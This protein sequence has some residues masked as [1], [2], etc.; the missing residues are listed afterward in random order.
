MN[1]YKPLLLVGVFF[2]LVASLSLGFKTATTVRLPSSSDLVTFYSTQTGDHLQET[3]LSAIE[4]AKSSIELITFTMRDKRVI[5]ALNQQAKKGVEV[6]VIYDSKAADNL[7]TQ[8][9]SQVRKVKRD[10]RGITHQKILIIDRQSLFVGTANLTVG[11]LRYYDNLVNGFWSPELA[12]WVGERLKG[13]DGGSKGPGGH[14][15]VTLGDQTLEFWFL[16]DGPKA[17]E[18]VMQLIRSAQKTLDIAMFTW[19]R[20]DFAQ[21]VIDAKNRG[22][23]VTVVIDR[24]SSTGASAKVVQKLKQGGVPLRF[25]RSDELMHTKTMVV[26]GALL[27]SGSANWTKSAFSRNDDCFYVLSP[28][29]S[30][31]QE[32]LQTFFSKL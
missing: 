18:R 11:S 14:K 22:V 25:G 29:K 13:L 2:A 3:Y 12:Q 20:L 17:P 23:N 1:R 28:L 26:D 19:T 16:P 10:P 27:V 5:H 4:S 30:K 24:Q 7:D 6:T 31:E 15:T 9:A 32:I 21:E 8:L